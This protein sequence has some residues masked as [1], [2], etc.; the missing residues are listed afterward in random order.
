LHVGVQNFS[1][2]HFLTSYNSDFELDKPFYTAEWE[3]VVSDTRA[4]NYV[5]AGCCDVGV[6]LA[7]FGYTLLPGF[8]YI[9]LPGFG[10]TLLQGFGYMLLQGYVYM[11]LQEFG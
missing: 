3:E 9:L 4:Q 2:F 10:Y 11:L 8:G 6:L 7:G 5:V 1:N